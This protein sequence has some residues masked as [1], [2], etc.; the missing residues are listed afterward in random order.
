MKRYIQLYILQVIF[1]IPS[2]HFTCF[3]KVKCTQNVIITLRLYSSVF[4]LSIFY[5]ACSVTKSCL[6][7]GNPM[8]CIPQGSSVHGIFQA[9]VGCHILLQGIF[10]TQRL[11]PHFLC[12][13]QWQGQILYHWATWA[14]SENTTTPHH[15][16]NKIQRKRLIPWTIFYVSL[17]YRRSGRRRITN[18]N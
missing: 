13:L 1:L 10:F 6:T 2:S 18:N 4:I 7:L 15:F 12:H 17:F 5:I 11:N 8:D 16:S 9:R 14:K 3:R